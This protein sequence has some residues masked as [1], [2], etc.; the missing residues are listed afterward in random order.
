MIKQ[1]ETAQEGTQIRDAL[2]EK[3]AT[4]PELTN[5]DIADLAGLSINT[6]NHCLSDR[7]KSSSAYTIG[8]LCRALHVSFD[9]FFGIIPEHSEDEKHLLLEQIDS[10]EKKCSSL[11]REL[12]H[13]E[14]LEALCLKTLTEMNG[15]VKTARRISIFA[16]SLAAVLIVLFIAYLIA[17]DIPLHDM[18]FFHSRAA[19]LG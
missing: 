8:C 17:F 5:Q 10:L 15:R 18:G 19:L 1:E 13:K 16:F 12:S 14:N 3:R 4:M 6:V 9:K 7:S 2:R 11:E